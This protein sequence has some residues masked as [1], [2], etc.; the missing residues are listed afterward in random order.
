ML[1]GNAVFFKS[2]WKY[3]FDPKNTFILP[4]R[5]SDGKAIAG[6]P[7]MNIEASLPLGYN[8]NL[9]AEILE[10]PYAVSN[11]LFCY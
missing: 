5:N 6:V 9:E 7:M 11:L 4:F 1:I 2:K 3:P 10:I 8:M